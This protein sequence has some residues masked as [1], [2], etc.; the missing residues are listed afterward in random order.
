[1]SVASIREKELLALRERRD[2]LRGQLGEVERGE[3][4]RSKLRARNLRRFLREVDARLDEIYWD[5]LGVPEWRRAGERPKLAKVYCVPA[6][7]RKR[8]IEFED[9]GH[10]VMGVKPT[11]RLR[12]GWMVFVKPSDVNPGE[13]EFVREWPV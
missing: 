12:V 11:E 3:D 10:G 4:D 9:G 7:K 8:F 2:D 5:V 1:M 13:W 6:N